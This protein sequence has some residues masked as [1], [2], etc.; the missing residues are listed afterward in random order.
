MGMAG[1]GEGQVVY[2]APCLLLGPSH[3]LSV[4]NGFNSS[5]QRDNRV[6]VD[7]VNVSSRKPW[8]IL[9]KKKNPHRHG[10]LRNARLQRN[11]TPP[12]LDKAQGPPHRLMH[13]AS[14]T[15]NNQGKRHKHASEATVHA[16]DIK[17]TRETQVVLPPPRETVHQKTVSA[18]N[19]RCNTD[20]PGHS[21]TSRKSHDLGKLP[22]RPHRATQFPRLSSAFSSSCHQHPSRPQH[23]AAFTTFPQVMVCILAGTTSASVSFG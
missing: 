6:P 7:M 20:R 4:D 18:V 22:P 15:N 2:P 19:R 12:R 5:Q 8:S 13:P 10:Q 14:T 11:A 21:R 17:L 16:S 9:N 3:E 23:D 1:E